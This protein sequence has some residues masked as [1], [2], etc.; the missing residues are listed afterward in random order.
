MSTKQ[1]LLLLSSGARPRYLEDIVRVL[2]LP[3]GGRIQFRYQQDLVADGVKARLATGGLVGHTCYLAYLDNRARGKKPEIV[4]VREAIILEANERGSSL[5]LSMRVSR[6]VR[7]NELDRIC[8]YI[9]SN[10]QDKLPAWRADYDKHPDRPFEGYWINFLNAA[11][12]DT[13]L[14]P[15]DAEAA[16]HLELFE[17]AVNSLCAHAD[18]FGDPS[19]RMFFNVIGLKDSRGKPIALVHGG[20]KLAPGRQY[21]LDLYH[22]CPEESPLVK[23]PT[24]WI[25]CSASG[26]AVTVLG[27]GV[28]RADSSYDSH[29]IMVESTGFLRKT[30]NSLTVAIDRVDGHHA[31]CLVGRSDSGTVGA[32]PR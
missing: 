14:G 2:A 27:N 20:W 32:R 26:P 11:L 7:T 5:I 15:H 16:K 1:P 3:E 22:Y 9:E 31:L 23:R 18:D 17:A 12:S 24:F 28:L 29:V 13:Q 4:P 25:K 21:R 6:Y 30:Q 19:R 10:I 8:A